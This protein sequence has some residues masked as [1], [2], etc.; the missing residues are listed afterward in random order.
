V[1]TSRRV[2]L[3]TGSGRGIGRAIALR[4]AA[5][6]FDLALHYNRSQGSTRSLESDVQGQGVQSVLVPGDLCDPQTPERL[7]AATL[8]HFGRLD[9]LVNNAGTYSSTKLEMVTLALW[10]ET[11][12]LNLRAVFFLCQA[13][14]EP[15]RAHG[16]GVIVNLASDGGLTPQPGFPVSAPYATSKAGVIM[17]TKILAIELAPTIRVNAVAPGV[18]ASKR[19]P[20]PASTCEKY[21]SLTPLRRVGT[22]SD[23]AEVVAFLASD[24][25]RFITG[26]IL[27]VDGGLGLR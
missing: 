13:A 7:I 2:A 11:F 18:I 17:L 24:A 20:M 15:L 23:V 5:D 3:I 21:A 25:A 26:Q 8:A 1:E 9:V 12:T 6:G 19:R 10:E 22:P 4:L 14:A 16:N 27:A